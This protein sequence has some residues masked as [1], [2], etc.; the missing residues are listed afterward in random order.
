[1]E[2]DNLYYYYYNMGHSKLMDDHTRQYVKDMPIIWDCFDSHLYSL[3]KGYYD[4]FTIK[5]SFIDEEGY[6]C[7][8]LSSD[9]CLAL[10]TIKLGDDQILND[11]D[12]E[13]YIIKKR[14]NT[15]KSARN[16]TFTE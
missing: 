9:C 13:E 3:T 1:M 4:N 14:F 12:F 16:R 6:N 10:V 8:P 15:T 7:A 5:I 11:D 2:F